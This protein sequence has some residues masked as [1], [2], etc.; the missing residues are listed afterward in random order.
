MAKA[1]HPPGAQ[2][3]QHTGAT[4]R[5]AFRSV[6]AQACVGLGVVEVTPWTG[7]S[8]CFIVRDITLGD[9]TYESNPITVF[10]AVHLGYRFR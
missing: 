5:E 1:T 2:A 8:R 7:V 10:P 9:A 3:G 4:E 6:A